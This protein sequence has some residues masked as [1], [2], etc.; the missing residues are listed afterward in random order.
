MCKH[1]ATDFPNRGST[2]RTSISAIHSTSK[3]TRLPTFSFLID[4]NGNSDKTSSSKHASAD[5]TAS[6]VMPAVVAAL[7]LLLPVLLLLLLRA[8]WARTL[9]LTRCGLKSRR[10]STKWLRRCEYFTRTHREPARLIESFT[11]SSSIQ[12]VVRGPQS[13]HA[14]VYGGVL[15]PDPDGD[16]SEKSARRR[17][18]K[19]ILLPWSSRKKISNARISSL[20]SL[21]N[22][23]DERE[24]LVEEGWFP[25]K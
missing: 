24:C 25:D 14:I 15:V 16:A 3:N 11:G 21:L 17:A 9:M 18:T 7:L 5:N 2:L 19:M 20:G 6:V 8:R 22:G 10:S 4:T 13:S 23:N 1:D 12:W